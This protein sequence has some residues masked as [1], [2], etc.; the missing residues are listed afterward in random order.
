[1]VEIERSAEPRPT[2]NATVR[3]VVVAD[4]SGL[5]DELAT[6]PL[7]KS[8]GVVVRDELAK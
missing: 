8:F 1:M 3:P 5:G 7:M 4:R 2:L 6:E